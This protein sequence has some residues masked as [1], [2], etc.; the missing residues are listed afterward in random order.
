MMKVSNKF[1]MTTKN[2][3]DNK[4]QLFEAQLCQI[5]GITQAKA[6]AIVKK[7]QSVT[8]LIDAI[9]SVGKEEFARTELIVGVGVSS[10]QTK[11]GNSISEK[12][13][14]LFCK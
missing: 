1:K 3:K 7:Y 5:N 14:Q 11:I 13:Y 8:E 4:K 10:R 12:L 6:H 2:D 9:E